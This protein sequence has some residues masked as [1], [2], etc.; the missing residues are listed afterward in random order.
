MKARV[1]ARRVAFLLICAFLGAARL[2]AA[3]IA[4]Q[5]SAE[6][7]LLLRGDILAGDLD[8]LDDVAK[9]VQGGTLCLDSKG[10]S[11]E[12]AVQIIKWLQGALNIATHIQ[13]G[14]VCYSACALVFMFGHQYET[15]GVANSSRSMHIEGKLGFH[16]PYVS[17]RTDSN[18]AELSARAYRSGIRSIGRLLETDHSEFIPKTLLVEML[19]KEPHEFLYVDTVAKA[20]SWNVHLVGVQPPAALSEAMLE[21]SCLNRTREWAFRPYRRWWG[22]EGWPHGQREAI[23]APNKPVK[24]DA[25]HQRFVFKKFGGDDAFVC[26]VDVYRD[27]MQ[28]VAIDVNF[29][30]DVNSVS[31]PLKNPEIRNNAI[32]NGPPIWYVYPATRKIDSLGR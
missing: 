25:K 28:R 26:V 13:K 27:G 31:K 9:A 11:F 30:E 10:G 12:E 5:R 2:E 1:Y 16:S 17:P 18:A 32:L 19:K 3:E 29:G 4:L 7:T 21:Q 20:A 23:T 24:A 6:C 15:D 22:A 14:S 8:A